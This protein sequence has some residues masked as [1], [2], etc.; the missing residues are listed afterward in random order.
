MVL[1]GDAPLNFIA[2][3][4]VD[5]THLCGR[6]YELRARLPSYMEQQRAS[7]FAHCP[8]PGVLQPLEADYAALT[9]EDVWT[10]GMRVS[11]VD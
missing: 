3:L 1:L 10:D 7:I 11:V 9:S 4:S 5:Q 2:K 6:G 8:L